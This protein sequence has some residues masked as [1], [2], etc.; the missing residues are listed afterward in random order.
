MQSAC[1]ANFHRD[2]YQSL[3]LFVPA[4]ALILFQTF[5]L[6]TWFSFDFI[7]SLASLYPSVV[8]LLLPKQFSILGS[9]GIQ[10]HICGIKC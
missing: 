10:H 5:M 4:L 7:L 3:F 1:Y 9:K 8:A 2:N 6:N